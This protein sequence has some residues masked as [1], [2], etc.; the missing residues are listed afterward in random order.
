MRSV[1][2]LLFF[3]PFFSI[4]A[5]PV[6]AQA[7]RKAADQLYD[8]MAYAQATEAYKA[9]LDKKEPSLEIVQRIAHGYRFM[10]NSKEAEFWYA[11]VLAFPSAASINIFY[12]AEAARRNGN[13]AKARE[14]FLQYG[15]VVTADAAMAR[16]MADACETAQKWQENPLAIELKK[17]SFNSENSDFSPVFFKEGIVF[18]SDRAPKSK[19]DEAELYAWN[20]RPFLQLYYAE[21]GKSPAGSKT[22]VWNEPVAFPKQINT[23][24][25]N[26]VATFS[27]DGN[28]IFFTRSS[29]VKERRKK[30]N[31]DPTSWVNNPAKSDFV[32][33]LEI[34]VSNFKSGAWTEPKGF[35]YNKPKEYSVGHPALSADGQ[36]LYFASDMPGGQGETD[37]YYCTR[38]PNG[39]WSKPVNCGP[40]INTSGRE[41]FPTL[42]GDSTLHFSSDGHLGMGGLDLFSAKGSKGKWQEVKNLQA[43]FNSGGDDFGL[44]WEENGENGYFSSNRDS[45]AGTDN[46]YF[47]KPYRIPCTLEGRTVEQPVAKQSQKTAPKPLANVM[48]RLYRPNDTTAQVTYSDADGRFSFPIEQGIQYTLKG[49]KSGYL[50]KSADITPECKSVLD[51]IKLDM[52]LNQNVINNSYIVENIYYDLDKHD[53]REDAAKELDKLVVMLRDNPEVKIELSSHTDSR[54][55]NH[56]NQMLSQ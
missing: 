20:G 40:S 29:K 36:T 11:Q 47:F 32:N 10:N 5:H 38:N 8:G 56:Y 51:M 4:L 46:I 44:I 50:T 43:P 42:N 39:S 35:A 26:A 31:T 21:K 48:L 13:Y 9:L 53:I 27:K 37:I 14:L 23:E 28:T 6:F 24:Y 18:A 15:R 52:T 45:D 19:K 12:Y 49:I 55:S 41:S 33:R 16:K 17:E 2:F 34:Y 54:Q 7:N 22:T 25:H 30:A 3:L 1:L